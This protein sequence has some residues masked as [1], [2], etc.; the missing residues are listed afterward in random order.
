MTSFKA[1]S[2]G[3]KATRPTKPLRLTGFLLAAVSALMLGMLAVPATPASADLLNPN[4]KLQG[5]ISCWGYTGLV[6]TDHGTVRYVWVEASNGERGWATRTG[7][8]SSS[9]QG[10]YFQFR[11]VPRS[12]QSISVTVN[13]GC[14]NTERNQKHFT[15]SFGV[16]RPK[17]G[18]SHTVNI[19]PARMIRCF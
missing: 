6:K 11:Q 19:C 5:T 8:L 4:V 16:N 14:G 2:P 13:W 10:Y 15:T 12:G 17:V 3:H 7:N 1:V 9:R 18:G